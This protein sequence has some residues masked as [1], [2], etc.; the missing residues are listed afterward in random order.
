D[1]VE[2]VNAFPT[3]DHWEYNASEQVTYISWYNLGDLSFC[4]WMYI[5]I[6]GIAVGENS[7]IDENNVTAIGEIPD[8]QNVS[9]QDSAFI[10]C[11]DCIP[12]IEIEKYVWDE[13]TAEW[14][15]ANDEGQAVDVHQYE[16]ATFLISIHNTGTCC[17]LTD[18]IVTDVMNYS[19]VFVNASE[20]YVGMPVSGPE[21]MIY[22]W[23]F[24]GP[25]LPCNYI[26]FTIN[27][28]VMEPYCSVD[29]NYVNVTAY[30]NLSYSYVYDEDSAFVHAILPYYKDVGTDSIDYPTGTQTTGT[31][32][33]SAT[34]GNY[35][36]MFVEDIP[37]NCSIYNETDALVYGHDEMISNISVGG[38]KSVEFNT[39][40]TV[41]EDGDYTINVT[42]QHGE[43]TVPGNDGKEIIVTIDDIHDV[44]T[45][46]IN[47][48]TGTNPTGSYVVNATV[49]NYGNVD[50]TTSFDVELDIYKMTYSTPI[51]SEDFEGSFPPS[52]WSVVNN[53]GTCVW[54]RNDLVGTTPRDNYAGTGYC[55]K[56]EFRP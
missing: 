12:S 33:V 39:S 21:G 36:N 23:F 52:G 16:N 11:V 46:S 18:I 41:T 14:A 28:T 15:N 54:D 42:T 43:D 22:T 55:A 4:E 37:V 25:L 13:E 19:M 47:S 44:G 34:I 31:Y 30:C 38:F 8:E 29:E 35:G 10:H 24:A 53:G 32:T 2:Y 7:S 5:T 6:D 50:E 51:F 1:S 40:W 49:K 45:D 3:P 56:G 9:D 27:A 48:P 17:G 26:N 20:T